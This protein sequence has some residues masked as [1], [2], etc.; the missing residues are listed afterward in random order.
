VATWLVLVLFT[1][2]CTGSGG[3]DAPGDTAMDAE[4]AILDARNDPAAT[5]PQV[6]RLAVN[7]PDALR[8]A[9]M[10]HIEDA[11]PEVRRA[12][13]YALSFSVVRED[14]PAVEELRS[15]LDAEDEGDKLTAAGGLLSIGEKAAIPV[16]IDLLGSDVPIPY[17]DPPLEVW[18]VARGLLL[19]HTDQDLG[20]LSAADAE[21]AAAVQDE[22]RGWWGSS[23]TTLTWDPAAWRFTT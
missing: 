7:D 8:S 20:L 5:I 21:A 15:F 16:L 9:A 23:E 22:W 11:D 12:A 6:A 10:A 4:R 13:L 17:S 14:G 1:G 18:E 19:A 3:E 2:A